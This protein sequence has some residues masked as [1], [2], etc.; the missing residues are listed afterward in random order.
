MGTQVVN[1]P[2]WL[3]R[4][5]TPLF[6]RIVV[7]GLRKNDPSISDEQILDRVRKDVGPSPDAQELRFLEAVHRRAATGRPPAETTLAEPQTWYS[8]SSLALIASHLLPLWGVLEWGWPVFPLLVL[9][10]MENVVV[11]VLCVARMVLVDP[12]DPVLWIAKLFLIPFFCLHY[13]M[14]TGIHGWIVFRLFGGAEYGRMSGGWLP[15]HPAE[16][17]I[18]SYGLWLPLMCLAASHLFWFMWDYIL[19]GGYRRA[20]LTRLM[21]QPYGRVFV[22]HLTIIFGG[23]AVMLLGSPVWALVVLIA[24]KVGMDLKAH[25]RP[26]AK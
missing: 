25:L 1:A 13:G 8:P 26:L 11:G 17:A 23:W 2:P 7:N 19:R 10:W 21:G 15:V 22:L 14:F 5:L 24:I 6:A 4:L 9:F 12:V 20:A 3:V 16:R 18:A